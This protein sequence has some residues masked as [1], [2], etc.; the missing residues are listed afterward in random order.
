MKVRGSI[1]SV[2]NALGWKWQVRKLLAQRRASS[3]AHVRHPQE[4]QSTGRTVATF[5]ASTVARAWRPQDRFVVRGRGAPGA[6]TRG[7]PR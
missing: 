7:R 1:V 2:T 3:G 4:R 5:W 6:F